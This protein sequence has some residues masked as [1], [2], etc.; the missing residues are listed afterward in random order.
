M[1]I[2]YDRY[3]GKS[4]QPLFTQNLPILNQSVDSKGVTHSCCLIPNNPIILFSKKENI[5]LVAISLIGET[6]PCLITKRYYGGE[7]CFEAIAKNDTQKVYFNVMNL[8][9][10]SLKVDMI[11]HTNGESGQ[12]YMEN[13]LFPFQTCPVSLYQSGN[14]PA[15]IPIKVTTSKD[16][17]SRILCKDF[18][19]SVAPR[20]TEDDLINI[21]L[22][23]V[24]WD[25]KEIIIIKEKS[26]PSRFDSELAHSVEPGKVE[27][28][29]NDWIFPTNIPTSRNLTFCIEPGLMIF[30][31][32]FFPK[33]ELE[34]EIGKSI[35]QSIDGIPFAREE[36]RQIEKCLIC[37]KNTP[38]IIF[39]TCGHKC[40]CVDCMTECVRIKSARCRMCRK[41]AVAISQS[42]EL[43]SP[44]QTQPGYCQLI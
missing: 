44:P 27:D 9:P 18:T 17:S 8:S 20:S 5:P 39:Y 36:S 34:E 24:Y 42:I 41:L 26:D 16:Q 2:C 43:E 14:E 38:F 40:L 30:S 7:L 35:Q 29:K 3:V 37:L 32:E 33:E 23:G 22:D 10:Y 1:I 15:N 12:D 19:I 31:Q 6:P 28:D 4:K 11:G 13:R 21:M 25:C